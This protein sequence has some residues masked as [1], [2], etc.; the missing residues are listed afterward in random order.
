LR[1]D[2]ARASVRGGQRQRKQP[3]VWILGEDR[4]SGHEGEDE[5]FREGGSGALRRRQEGGRLRG[6]PVIRSFVRKEDKVFEEG[7]TGWIGRARRSLSLFPGFVWP[8]ANVPGGQLGNRKGGIVCYKCQGKGTSHRT[9]PTSRAAS[10]PP[11][12]A[13]PGT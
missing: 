7:L 11:K 12:G 2:G 13:F 10:S 9:A 3:P 6:R 5:G 4:E 1:I 8:A